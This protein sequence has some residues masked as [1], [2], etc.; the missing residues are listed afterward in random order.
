MFPV[1]VQVSEGSKEKRGKLAGEAKG[2]GA[3][4]PKRRSQ[5][6]LRGDINGTYGKMDF[7]TRDH[8]RHAVEKI[9]I[10][11]SLSEKTVA[12]RAISNAKK[13]MTSKR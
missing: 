8:Y 7:H 10:C 9:A 11:S 4:Q 3:R 5:T 13:T 12:E 1:V 6:P 2:N